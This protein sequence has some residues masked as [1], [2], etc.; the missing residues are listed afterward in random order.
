M[1]FFI[2]ALAGSGSRM[3][4]FLN[5]NFKNLTTFWSYRKFENCGNWPR[6]LVLVFVA[7]AKNLP[8]PR[9]PHELPWP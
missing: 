4:N 8:S 9:I 3:I 7:K 1:G 2:H 6:A 5:K